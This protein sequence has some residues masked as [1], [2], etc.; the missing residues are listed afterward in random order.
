MHFPASQFVPNWTRPHIYQHLGICH[1]LIYSDI[2]RE[3]TGTLKFTTPTLRHAAVTQ[4]FECCGSLS[5]RTKLSVARYCTS[6]DIFMTVK[7]EIL[8]EQR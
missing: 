2:N 6:L 3:Q 5:G 8:K 1:L 4:R 7:G